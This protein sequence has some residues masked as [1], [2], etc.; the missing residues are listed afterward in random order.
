[1]RL[2]DFGVSVV[3]P[4][5]NKAPYIRRTLLSVLA[6]TR[7]ADE[8]VIVDDGSTDGSA[9][10][11]PPTSS[12]ARRIWPSPNRRPRRGA[13][14]AGSK[15][16]QPWIALP[17][18]RRPVAARPSRHDRGTCPY[19]PGGR[20]AGD[21]DMFARSDECGFRSRPPAARRAAKKR[22][23]ISPKSP[24]PLRSAPPPSRRGGRPCAPPGVRRVWPARTAIC[25]CASPW[26]IYSPRPADAPPS[27]SSKPAA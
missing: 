3:I 10:G 7:A 23:I 15:S 8:I 17:R 21:G 20:P 24:S 22:S 26:T 5:Y 1:M 16:D 6:Q 4:L 11:D 13:Q 19:L 2:S 9:A 12:A 14:S 25:G 27:T 18:R